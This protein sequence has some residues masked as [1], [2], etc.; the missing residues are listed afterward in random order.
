MADTKA[1]EKSHLPL[2]SSHQEKWMN[3]LM[4]QNAALESEVSRLCGELD[5]AT[6]GVLKRGYLYKYRDRSISFAS[7]W[8]LRYFVLNGSTISYYANELDNRPRRTIDLT[9][10]NVHADGTKKGGQF[11]V[12]CVYLASEVSK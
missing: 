12:F 8:G 6:K 1:V 3:I 4:E 9:H 7:N 2:I 10:C 5:E 11:N